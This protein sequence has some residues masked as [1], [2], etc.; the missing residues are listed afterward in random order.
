VNTTLIQILVVDDDPF[1]AEM[2]GMILEEPE[3][4]II[5]ANSGMEALGILGSNPLIRLVVSDMNMPGINGIQL[6]TGMRERGFKIPFVLLTGDESPPLS[7]E[8][9]MDAII[10]KDEDVEAILPKT[11]ALLLAKGDAQPPTTV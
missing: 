11:V 8:Y 3:Y 2:T 1:T 10:A 9:P 4:E 5:L 6:F 7:L